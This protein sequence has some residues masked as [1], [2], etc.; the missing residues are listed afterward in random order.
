MGMI[1]YWHWEA[2]LVSYLATRVLTLPF[3]GL[4]ELLRTSTFRVAIIPASSQEDNFKLSNNSDRQW[5]WKDRIEPYLD[6]YWSDTSLIKL[7]ET[8]PEIAIYENFFSVRY[9]VEYI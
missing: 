6:E 5:A 9:L 3:H 2:M 7:L 1:F 8:D 4:P